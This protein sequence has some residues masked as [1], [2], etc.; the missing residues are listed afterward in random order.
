MLD[1]CKKGNSTIGPTLLHRKEGTRNNT[2]F[3]DTSE[4]CKVIT[5]N[6]SAIHKAHQRLNT[7]SERVWKQWTRH[8]F[9]VA[10]CEVRKWVRAVGGV[11]R[12]VGTPPEFCRSS[13]FSI[14]FSLQDILYMGRAS[15]KPNGKMILSK[16]E[17]SFN[18][19]CQQNFKIKW[20][21]IAILDRDLKSISKS[22][23]VE[24]SYCVVKWMKEIPDGFHIEE[25]RWLSS[26]GKSFQLGF[27]TQDGFL[28]VISL[29]Q[30]VEK[31]SGTAV[32]RKHAKN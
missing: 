10:L 1:H 13:E 22:N 18:E 16:S 25:I 17:E 2:N 6:F 27:N 5:K 11:L 30:F 23:K 29:S 19:N 28:Q 24:I 9:W 20:E 15:V 7:R 21:L 3:I 12:W 8:A 4:E 14:I 32:W 31:T 26:I